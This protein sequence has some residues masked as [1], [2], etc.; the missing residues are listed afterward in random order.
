MRRSPRIEHGS[1]QI[2]IA[3]NGTGG[4]QD[5]SAGGCTLTFDPGQTTKTINVSIMNDTLDEEDENFFVNLGVPANA[6][7][8]DGQGQAAITDDDAAPSITIGNSYAFENLDPSAVFQVTLSAA[9]GKTVSVNYQ[10]Q[11]HRHGGARL[12]GRHGSLNYR[13]R[14]P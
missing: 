3:A 14:C 8:A 4:M 2:D 5:Y 11:R 9:S 12:H 6:T 1:K 7:L 10:H 13:A